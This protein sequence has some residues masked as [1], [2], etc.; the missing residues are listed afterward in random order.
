MPRPTEVTGKEGGEG[1]GGV[2]GG[3][4]TERGEWNKRDGEK[5]ARG[6]T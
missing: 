1:D 6:E 5:R 3:C 4:N 2:E